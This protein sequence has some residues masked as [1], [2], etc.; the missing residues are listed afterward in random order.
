V[1]GDDT[2]TAVEVFW[3]HL[4]AAQPWRRSAACSASPVAWFFPTKGQRTDRAKAICGRCRVRSECLA[5]ALEH[6]DP[7]VWGGTT[8]R[9]R[10]MI[11]SQRNAGRR[12]AS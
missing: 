10:L 8:E 1:P 12:K 4:V 5:Y 9:E 11:S 7:G 3:R 6:D 2:L